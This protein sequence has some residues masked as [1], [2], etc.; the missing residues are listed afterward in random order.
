MLHKKGDLMKSLWTNLIGGGG[1]HPTD[2]L[3]IATMALT[4]FLTAATALADA[5]PA[6]EVTIRNLTARGTGCP[7]GSVDAMVSSDAKAF[8]LFFS[9]FIASAGPDQLIADQYKTCNIQLDLD[10]PHNWQYA[11][12][13]VD[14]R[15]Y[16]ALDRGVTA[17]L[18]TQYWT[19][20]VSGIPLQLRKDIRGPYAN[21]F[22][23][24]NFLAESQLA[25]TTCG[26]KR[27]LN[28]KASIAVR[29]FGQSTG[30]ITV[31][32]ID[33]ELLQTYKVR[34]RRC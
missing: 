15:G 1:R 9:E 6:N 20:G 14:Y 4:G 28:M 5:P 19:Q 21:E 7:V 23:E 11:V 2:S 17:T 25:W 24:S 27:A 34:W 3:M 31:D 16:A 8:T 18:R 13:G 33:G 26:Q 32:S 12:I 22:L 10:H 29:A 30:L